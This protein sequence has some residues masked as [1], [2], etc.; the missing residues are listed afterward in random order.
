MSAYMATQALRYHV[1]ICNDLWKEMWMSDISS[2]FPGVHWYNY[3]CFCSSISI[4][5]RNFDTIY[6]KFKLVSK[7][8]GI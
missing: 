5:S 2:D 7:F 6:H 1:V 4:Q 8:D 3:N